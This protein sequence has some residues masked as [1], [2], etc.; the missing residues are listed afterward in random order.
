MIDAALKI[1]G[2]RKR[3]D[4]VEVL[5]GVNTQMERGKVTAFIG[6]NGAGKTMLFQAI[7]GE[8]RPDAGR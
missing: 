7:T 6:P 8:I 4:D 3:I 5:A 1:E 2:L